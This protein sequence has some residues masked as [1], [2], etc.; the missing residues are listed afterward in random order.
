MPGLVYL[1]DAS[2]GGEESVSDEMG[3][4][5]GGRGQVG[6]NILCTYPDNIPRTC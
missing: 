5:A 6:T 2:V 3:C 4:S 1:D